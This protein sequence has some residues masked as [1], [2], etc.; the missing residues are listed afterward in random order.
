MK[1]SKLK[2]IGI[3]KKLFGSGVITLF[4]ILFGFAFPPLWLFILA[5]PFMVI[6]YKA[7][8]PCPVCAKWIEVKAKSGTA[9][10]VRC[11]TPLRIEHMHLIAEDR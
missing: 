8:G 3:V 11:K 5:G 9:W 2:K 6:G 4:I 7:E 10:C 1:T